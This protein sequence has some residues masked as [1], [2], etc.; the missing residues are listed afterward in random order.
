V[1]ALVN[2]FGDD[3]RRIE[4]ALEVLKESERLFEDAEGACDHDILLAAA[5]LH[6]VG[7]KPAEAELGYNDG[8]SQERYGP[9]VARALLEEID[10]PAVKIAIVCEIIGNHH[11][12]SRYP[13][14]ELEI[15][16]AA[17]RLVNRRDA[18]PTSR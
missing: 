14:P 17:D 15:L 12:P 3:V 7:I 18:A 8:P 1:R 5:L 6:D 4:H 16:K 11:S 10:F 2:F 9:P 13:Y